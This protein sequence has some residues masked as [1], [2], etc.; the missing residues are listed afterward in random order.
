[1]ISVIGLGQVGTVMAAS[2]AFDGHRV[3]AFDC[4]AAKVDALRAG[5]TAIVE[6]ELDTLVASSI[7]AGR[8]QATEDLAEAVATSVVSIVCVGTPSASD[9]S[10]DLSQ[11]VTAFESIGKVLPGLRHYHLV[12]IRST[13]PPGTTRK[14]AIPIM[15]RASGRIAA[16]DFGVCYCPEF[17]REGEA[18]R[19]F[20]EPPKIVIGEKAAQDGD[21][22]L[23]LFPHSTD[24]AII[25][26]DFETA[27]MLKYIDNSWHALKVGFA[28]EIGSMAKA[29]GLDGR[30]LMSL[31]QRDTTLNIS[32]AY[33]APGA[34]YGG[35]CLPKDL[36][37]LRSLANE[38]NVA[39]PLLD[40]ITTSNLAHQHR[41]LQLV[42]EDSNA[43]VGIV[44]ASI[45]PGSGDIRGSPYV[46]L[47][48]SLARL[49]HTVRIY[50]RQL[51]SGSSGGRASSVA[52]DI[53]YLASSIREL[54]EFADVVVLC[55]LDSRYVEELRQS[56]R[57]SQ[58][59]VDLV[60]AGRE[61]AGAASYTGI[62]W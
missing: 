38:T 23:E 17:L 36:A 26:T 44:G 54:V 61:A 5:C 24:A 20:R 18:I 12:V 6:P 10:T 22:V 15:E 43:R 9:G 28:N 39:I 42:G 1:M 32:P 29:L 27:E 53:A 3:I 40:A 58:R 2:L 57:P 41:V 19:D 11:L 55:H 48:E 62:C 13:A 35:S 4:D 45:K 50:D 31:F 7:A 16:R 51:R 47:A 25:R 52:Q 37:A 21:I 33:L 46:G 8:L 14:I 49:G 56:M 30:E 60:G 59:M 34:P